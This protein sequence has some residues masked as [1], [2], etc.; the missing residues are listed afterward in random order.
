MPRRHFENGGRQIPGKPPARHSPG[1]LAAATDWPGVRNLVAKMSTKQVEKRVRR[2]QYPAPHPIIAL[3][4]AFGGDVRNVPR[5]HP[6]STASLFFHP[7]ARNLI[8]I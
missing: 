8:R 1:L 3:C 7:T 6:A 4:T 5:E 2:E